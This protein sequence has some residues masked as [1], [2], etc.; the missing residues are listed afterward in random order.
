MA[1]LP[2]D[3]A[4]RVWPRCRMRKKG[5]LKGKTGRIRKKKEEEGKRR[6]KLGE[7]RGGNL[8]ILMPQERAKPPVCGKET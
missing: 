4:Y 5:T 8:R 6:R 7:E 3:E 2:R 1:T